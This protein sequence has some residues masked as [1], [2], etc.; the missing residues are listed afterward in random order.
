MADSKTAK[1]NDP[2]RGTFDTTAF[3][4]FS[5]VDTRILL[6]MPRVGNVA[7]YTKI[8][9]NIQTISYSIFREKSP[10]RSL[11]FIGEKG[12]ARGTRTIAGSIVFTVFDRHPLFDFFRPSPGDSVYNGFAMPGS[13]D[14]IEYTFPDQL[15]PFDLILHFANEYGHTSELVLQG[16][17]LSS[18]GQVHSVQ[19][20][21]TE[22]TMQFTAGNA[23]MMHP[24]GYAKIEGYTEVT[25]S[26]GKSKLV[27]MTEAPTFTSIMNKDNTK[28][29]RRF[30]DRSRARFR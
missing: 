15:P 28:N 22:N 7:A 12:R 19:D 25:D 29:L 21:I 8:V 17:D 4:S 6:S 9:T 24:G 5:G 11:G 13:Y 18:E 1:V 20:I 26:T 10:V 30:I 16:I 14:G 3:N 23:I 27:A 2:Y